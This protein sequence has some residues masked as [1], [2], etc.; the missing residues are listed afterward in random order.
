MYAK[1]WVCKGHSETTQTPVLSYV[2]KVGYSKKNQT[3]KGKEREK[4][5]KGKGPSATH[6][7]G[8]AKECAN[9]TEHLHGPGGV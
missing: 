8:E 2:S 7:E 9:S 5:L 4:S 6:G 3:H 1:Q